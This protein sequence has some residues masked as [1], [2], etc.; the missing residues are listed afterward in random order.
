MLSC[1]RYNSS[2]FRTICSAR[3]SSIRSRM[4]KIREEERK[5]FGTQR[6]IKSYSI[7]MNLISVLQAYKFLDIRGCRISHSK[8]TTYRVG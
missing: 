2:T 6:L 1:P 4:V 5:M 7:Y 3:K 8:E